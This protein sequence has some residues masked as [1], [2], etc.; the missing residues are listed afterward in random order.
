MSNSME[1]KTFSIF[2]SVGNPFTVEVR[3]PPP[4]THPNIHEFLFLCST[5][6]KVRLGKFLILAT[7][8]VRK[9]SVH[10]YVNVYPLD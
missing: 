8:I 2:L 6:Y 4:P 9:L 7:H 1:S 10:L 5:I 3:P